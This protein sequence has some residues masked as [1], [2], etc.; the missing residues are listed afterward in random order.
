MP[1]KIPQ[2]THQQIAILDFGSQYTHLI[3]R[4]LRDIHVWSEMYQ[5]DVKASALKKKNVIG[6]I[7]SGGPKSVY[8]ESALKYDRLIFDTNVPI[9]GL[10]YRHQLIAHHFGGK[11]EKGNVKEYGFATLKIKNQKFKI[12]NTELFENLP[13][14]ITVWMSHGDSVVKLPQDFITLAST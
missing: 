1:Q 12:S 9:L 4:R 8:D 6:V 14:K 11:V 3:S 7:L 13:K 10:C 2:K 5:P